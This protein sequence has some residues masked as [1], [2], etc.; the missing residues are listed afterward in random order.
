M[1]ERV[2]MIRQRLEMTQEQLAQRL[3]IGKA[4]LSMIETG[5]AGLSA[6]NKGTLVQVFNVS[7]EW[8]E[9]GEGEMFSAQPISKRFLDN[10]LSSV[11]PQSVPLYTI[12]GAT[13]VS[14][15]LN[16]PDTITPQS[17]VF[18]P[19]LPICDGAIH[20]NGD[21]MHPILRSGD[22]VLY[23]R[24]TDLNNIFWGEIYL[25]AIDID[26]DEYVTVRHLHKA[27]HSDKVRLVSQNN[28]YSDKEIEISKIN[29]LAIIKASIRLNSIK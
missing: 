2:R 27:D 13:S 5:K 19:N 4:A 3:G 15:L 23:K 9:N 24:I 7:A 25:I 20:V 6:R 26:G 12:E 18:I 29:A 17:F 8:L 28:G 21:S 14:T 11:P 1:N 10:S 22:I 16:N